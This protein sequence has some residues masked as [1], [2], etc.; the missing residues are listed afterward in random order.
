[1]QWQ[2]QPM[3]I[4]FN[5]VGEKH[6]PNQRYFQTLFTSSSCLEI[7][8]LPLYHGVSRVLQVE[9]QHLWDGDS[10]GQ[11]LSYLL[12]DLPSSKEIFGLDIKEDKLP[13][14]SHLQAAVREQQ[15]SSG[16]KICTIS[17]W[18][19]ARGSQRPWRCRETWTEFSQFSSPREEW[20]KNYLK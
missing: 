8:W 16:P 18:A 3:E 10:A 4:V 9:L 5:S 12:T 11:T 1:M 2:I 20:R 19:L 14:P 17:M 7:P 15:L 6:K 13:I